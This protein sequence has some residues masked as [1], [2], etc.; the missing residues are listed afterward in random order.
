MVEASRGQP[1]LCLLRVW[2]PASAA[3]SGSLETLFLI[4]P[5]YRA[6][7]GQVDNGQGHLPWL[8]AIRPTPMHLRPGH[9]SGETEAWYV[10][11]LLDILQP[12]QS[13]WKWL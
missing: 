2:S 1:T 7:Q 9:S 8:A 5:D 11:W 4:D 13:C 10:F 12:E 6:E 3:L